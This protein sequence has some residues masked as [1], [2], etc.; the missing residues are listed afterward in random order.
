MLHVYV[1]RTTISPSGASCTVLVSP[2]RPFLLLLRATLGPLKNSLLPSCPCRFVVRKSK[3]K[4]RLM[5]YNFPFL[6]LLLSSATPKESSRSLT[7]VKFNMH[8]VQHASK[9]ATGYVPRGGFILLLAAVFSWVRFS[10]DKSVWVYDLI[11]NTAAL[12]VVTRRPMGTA[13]PL[14]QQQLSI[15]WPS[16]FKSSDDLKGTDR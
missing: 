3:P 16:V 1:C 12:V 2:R 9:L 7:C 4:V 10:V 13:L 5:V 6:F 11:Y 15:W 8:Q 14:L